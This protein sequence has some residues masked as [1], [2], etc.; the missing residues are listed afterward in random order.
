ES[1]DAAAV[2]WAGLVA[3][4]RI[5]DPDALEAILSRIQ[6]S[7][8]GAGRA[9]AVL[10]AARLLMDADRRGEAQSLVER[11]LKDRRVSSNAIVKPELDKLRQ[12]LTKG[13]AATSAFVEAARSWLEEADILWWDHIEPLAKDQLYQDGKL[14]DYDEAAHVDA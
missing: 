10:A 4:G 3:A 9:G 1:K 13:E 12:E 2:L 8:M 14:L 6:S 5:E 7:D 11:E